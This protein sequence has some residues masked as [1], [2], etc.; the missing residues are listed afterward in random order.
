LS[1][2]SRRAEP[3]DLLGREPAG[4]PL[5]IEAVVGE[6]LLERPE[7]ELGVVRRQADRPPV[8]VRIRQVVADLAVPGPPLAGPQALARVAQ[9]IADRKAEQHALDARPG[10]RA[11][12]RRIGIEERAAPKVDEPGGEEIVQGLP[13]VA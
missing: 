1:R 5:R 8:G 2:N 10:G 11:A 7:R 4:E 12:R 6:Q 3:E 13:A 9:R